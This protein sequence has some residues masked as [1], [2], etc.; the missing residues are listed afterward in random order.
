[1]RTRLKSFGVFSLSA[2]DLFA[3]AMGAFIVISLVLMPDYQKEVRLEGHFRYIEA[4]ANEAEAQLDERQQGMQDRLQQLRAAQA[5][6]QELRVEQ[7]IVEGELASLESRIAAARRAPP[8]QPPIEPDP[9]PVASNQVTFR[10]LG[11]KTDKSR[12]L[13]MVD[14][15]GY[16]GQYESLVQDTVLRALDSLQPGM[17]FGLLVFQQLDTGPRLLRWPEGGGLVPASR[18]S[19]AGAQAFMRGQS[20]R[21]AGSSPLLAAFDEAF[22]SEAEALIL[23]SDGLPNPAFN[24]NLPA[25]ALA[26][27]ITLN[28][29]TG[30]EI[31][32]VTIG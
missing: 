19:R 14:M 2:I 10:F 24:D 17:E 3:S 31:H 28:N 4:L 6:H 11:L 12:Y 7:A 21:F 18:T 25:G 20:G 5:Q 15:N 32:A 30:K 8:P 13:V 27:S 26:R 9:E 16:L 1:M 29:T 23:I 22:S